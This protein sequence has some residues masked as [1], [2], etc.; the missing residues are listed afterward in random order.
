MLSKFTAKLCN[1]NADLI[2]PPSQLAKWFVN[3]KRD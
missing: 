2:I 1:Y 3:N